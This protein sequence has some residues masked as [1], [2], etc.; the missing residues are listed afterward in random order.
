MEAVSVSQI[1]CMETSRCMNE[2]WILH[3]AYSDNNLSCFVLLP[4]TLTKGI[5][6][7][8]HAFCFFSVSIECVG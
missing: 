7:R 4:P 8:T 6:A 1:L 2:T 3:I 5:F